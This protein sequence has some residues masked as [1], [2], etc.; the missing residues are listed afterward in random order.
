[1]FLKFASNYLNIKFHFRV[2]HVQ[3]QTFKRVLHKIISKLFSKVKDK[4][5][6]KKI[7]IS[8]ST[9]WMVSLVFVKN[10]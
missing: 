4:A 10:K 6:Y 8:N 1:M 9:D 3:F 2:V 5:I 7:K